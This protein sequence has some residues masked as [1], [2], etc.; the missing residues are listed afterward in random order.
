MSLPIIG[1]D[2]STTT[3]MTVGIAGHVDRAGV[4]HFTEE[5]IGS[6]AV[7]KME[8][9]HHRRMAWYNLKRRLKAS[10]ISFP[11]LPK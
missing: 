9:K 11:K 5:A 7:A 6:A 10:V 8:L 4:L 2:Y 3:D 1:I